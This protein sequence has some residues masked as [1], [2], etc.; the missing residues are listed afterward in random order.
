[1]AADC[2]A[3]SR[4]KRTAKVHCRFTLKTLQGDFVYGNTGVELTNLLAKTPLT[5]IR[6]H[7]KVTY[8]SLNA[9]SENPSLVQ[10]DARIRKSTI[11]MRDIRYFA[12]FLDT[13]EVMKPL[14]ARSFYIDCTVKGRMDN[15][16]I[17]NLKIKTLQQTHLLASAIV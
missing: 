3:G 12:P 16:V 10:V 1:Y 9:L 13:M 15:L 6:D 5:T 2:L 11:D 7:I 4:R 14:L 8:P 17:P